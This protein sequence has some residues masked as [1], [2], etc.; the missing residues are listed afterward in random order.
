MAVSGIRVLAMAATAVLAAG[1]FYGTHA[2]PHAAPHADTDPTAY[3]YSPI[4]LSQSSV[5]RAGLWDK[6]NQACIDRCEVFVNKGCFTELSKKNPTADA[7]SLLEQCEERFSL[8]LYK[9]MCDT[10]DENQIILK[11]P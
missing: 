1:Y 9:C 8:C 5:W 4:T 6:P 2:L 3:A 11:E 10:C 7:A